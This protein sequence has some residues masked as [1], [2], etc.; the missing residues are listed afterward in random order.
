VVHE[1]KLARLEKVVQLAVPRELERGL[2]EHAAG[3]AS[4]DW[5]T[6]ADDDDGGLIE[7]SGQA[8]RGDHPNHSRDGLRRP[9]RWARLLALSLWAGGFRIHRCEHGPRAPRRNYA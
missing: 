2:R 6:A 9:G 7:L 8:Q 3:G 5:K 4:V 1:S